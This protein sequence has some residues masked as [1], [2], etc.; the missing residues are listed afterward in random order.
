MLRCS[1]FRPSL[2]LCFLL[3]IRPPPR[4]TRLD[5]LLP[6]PALFRSDPLR[7]GERDQRRPLLHLRPPLRPGRR[8]GAG[9]V[10][11]AVRTGA[12]RG[13][14]TVDCGEPHVAARPAAAPALTPPPRQAPASAVSARPRAAPAC[15]RGGG[16]SACGQGG[17]AR[18]QIGRAHV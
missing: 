5:T 7:R 16:R 12:Q 10:L 14:G 18:C 8:P 1:N 11:P 2:C 3:T 13:G 6:P 15:P 4:S 9:S 17:A